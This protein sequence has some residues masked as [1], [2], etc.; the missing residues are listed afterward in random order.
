MIWDGNDERSPQGEIRA[1]VTISLMVVLGSDKAYFPTDL[2]TAIALRSSRSGGD[3]QRVASMSAKSWLHWPAAVQD[4]ST[5]ALTETETMLRLKSSRWTL[6]FRSHD[7]VVDV[8]GRSL[9]TLLPNQERSFACALFPYSFSQNR[10]MILVLYAPNSYKV[11]RAMETGEKIMP[12]KP[13]W[14]YQCNC[15][16]GSSTTDSFQITTYVSMKPAGSTAN[17]CEITK[18]VGSSML[19]TSLQDERPVN[20]DD[21][22]TNNRHDLG[23]NLHGDA[24]MGALD[25]LESS[26]FTMLSVLLSFADLVV[27]AQTYNSRS[28][29]GVVLA[30][31]PQ[32]VRGFFRSAVLMIFLMCHQPSMACTDIRGQISEFNCLDYHPESSTFSMTCSFSWTYNITKC[33][34]LQKNERFEG[35]GHSISLTGVANWE[36]LFRIATNDNSPSSLND[37]PVIHD[38]HMIGGETSNQGGF[39]IQAEQKHFIVKNSSSSGVIQGGCHPCK[40]GGGIC[41]LGCSGDILITHCW[42][43]GEIRG[44]SAGGIAGRVLGLDGGENN[45]VTISHCYSTGNIVREYSGGICG[46]GAGYNH[47]GKV[48]IE[49]C[50]SL[51]EIGGPHSGGIMG[52]AT[53]HTN[54]H[55]SII[56]CYSRGDISGSNN[57]GG[58][59]GANTG[60]SGGTVIL[61]NVY[62]SGKIDHKDAGGLIGSIAYD[63]A[64]VNI[65]MSVY[66]GDRGDMIGERSDD[67]RKQKNSGYL[68][69]IT[70]TVYCYSHNGGGEIKQQECWNNETIWQAVEGDFPIFIDKAAVAATTPTGTPPPS[71]PPISKRKRDAME[72]PVQYP[73]RSVIIKSGG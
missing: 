16:L 40:G 43:S 3:T 65:T 51:G 63:V 1:S 21:S 70:G 35:N 10:M 2:D 52:G 49:Q 47:K 46:M 31:L 15:I 8:D 34:V 4:P 71:R 50:Y 39:I 26:L 55:V 13:L 57:A 67:A 14:L 7:E 37:A 29:K 59:C 19:I 64:E 42:S 56:N 61:T 24:D 48:I 28:Y 53:S 69:D 45:T 72:L 12:T 5:I 22:S 9:L 68:G 23:G 62:A 73:I 36:G 11:P 58:I 20:N 18:H 25:G 60:W 17:S 33:I 27:Q 44:F 38:I 32:L 6:R 54:G 30:K 41:G 66:D